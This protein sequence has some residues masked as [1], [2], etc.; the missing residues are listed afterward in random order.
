MSI[1][2]VHVVYSCNGIYVSVNIVEQ[3]LCYGFILLV[4]KLICGDML[5]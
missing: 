4:G 3:I 1:S 2:S 5:H